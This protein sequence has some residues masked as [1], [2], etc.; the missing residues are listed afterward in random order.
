M[1]KQT[2]CLT[3]PVRLS[4]RRRQMVI[5]DA[6]GTELATRPIEDIGVVVLEHQ[7]STATLPLLCSLSAQNVAVILCDGKCMPSA[8]LMPLEANT[9]QAE[10][11][12]AQVSATEPCRKQM[13]KLIVEAK[14]HNQAR[15]LDC[16]GLRGDVLRPMYTAVKSGDSDNREGCAARVYWPMLFGH[17]F[18]RDR[19]GPPPNGLLNY[20]YAILR[21]A[22]ARAL[23]GSGLMPMLGIFHRNR[24]N[25]FPLA[26][27]VMEPYRPVIDQVVWRLHRDGHA[28]PDR[29]TK[30]ELL[31]TLFADVE[32]DGQR[33]PLENALTLTTASMARYFKGEDR[34]L[35]LPI[36]L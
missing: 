9:T 6:S 34:N 22:T 4:L 11:L 29:E 36:L 10:T 32:M 15:M 2:I 33:H 14:I 27:D 20:G 13:W 35:S 5:T 17:D 24:Y 26:D 21:A 23:L 25:A 12:R 31:G 3:T 19:G 18:L 1:L 28:V 16:A 8:M 30:T 7:Q